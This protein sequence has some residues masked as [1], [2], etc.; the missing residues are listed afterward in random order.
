MIVHNKPCRAQA[1]LKIS[2]FIL[3][4]AAM[5]AKETV[6]FLKSFS[7]KFPAIAP[8]LWHTAFAVAGSSSTL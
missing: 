5:D 6:D 4:I 3:R 8:A 2:D 7:G 1:F